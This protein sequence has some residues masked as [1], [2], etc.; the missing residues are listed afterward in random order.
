MD[1]VEPVGEAWKL[2]PDYHK[3]SDFL[4]VNVYDRQDAELAKKVYALK[5][6]A[7]GK[8]IND[9][10]WKMRGLQKELGHQFIGKPLILEMYKTIRLK[11]DREQH[12]LP[13]QP[14]KNVEVKEKP[15]SQ[16][17]IQK[18]VAETVNQAVKGMVNQ[19][20]GDKKMIQGAVQNALKEALK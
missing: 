15:K 14:V 17:S 20:L 6:W 11:Q 16:G 2:D 3:V 18:A 7:G 12:A 19:A 10:L 8:N 4:G 9:A 1:N 5:D 13:Q